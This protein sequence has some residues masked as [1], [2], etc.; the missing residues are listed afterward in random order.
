MTLR[1]NYK[2]GDYLMELD[3]KK[4]CKIIE[5]NTYN[6]CTYTILELG[7]NVKW[8]ALENFL[9]DYYIKIKLTKLIGELYGK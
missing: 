8:L 9:N 2:V 1:K 4:L 7:N 5:K 3:T 6:C